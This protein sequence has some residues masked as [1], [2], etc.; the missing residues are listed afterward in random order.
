MR[1]KRKRF[2]AT[3]RMTVLWD[4][5]NSLLNFFPLIFQCKITMGFLKLF[6]RPGKTSEGSDT[7]ECSDYSILHS[8]FIILHYLKP[9]TP[10]CWQG[11]QS[12]DGGSRTRVRREDQYASTRVVNHCFLDAALCRLTGGAAATPKSGFPASHA[13]H[14]GT[15]RA[16]PLLRRP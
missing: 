8:A 5:F 1:F 14:G 6:P 7:S 10:R 12:G 4:F 13:R 3:L 9:Q 11:V 2:F 16:T 15:E